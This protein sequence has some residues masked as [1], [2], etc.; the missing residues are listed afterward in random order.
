M[1]MRAGPIPHW[2]VL[3]G[4]EEYTSLVLVRYEGLTHISMA[5]FLWDIGK[6]NSP[7]CENAL[8]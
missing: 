2:L 3:A 1:L 4:R 5:S 7:R 8:T 6:Q